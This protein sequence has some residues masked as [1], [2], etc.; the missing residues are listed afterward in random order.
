MIEISTIEVGTL[1][2]NC[3]VVSKNGVAFIVDPGAEAQ[4]VK[5]HCDKHSLTVV[6]ILLTHGHYDHSGAV[7]ELQ[8]LTDAKIYATKDCITLANSM[9]SLAFAF[10]A[11]INKFTAD[12]TIKDGDHIIIGD[13]NIQVVATPGHTQG[14]VSYIVEDN[15]FTGDTLFQTSYGRTDLP[16]GDAEALEKSI[17]KLF[18]LDG[19]YKVYPG[20]GAPTTLDT[21]RK[22]NIINFQ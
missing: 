20:H 13:M 6:G 4:V 3:Y 1:Q 8:Q 2:T 12:L 5:E 10:G 15:I 21:E 9:K 14:G 16:T 22:H 7:K 18:A 17:K 19:E 11:S